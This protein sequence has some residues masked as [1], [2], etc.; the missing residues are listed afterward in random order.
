M[1]KSSLNRIAWRD[2]FTRGVICDCRMPIELCPV[3][4]DT[5]TRRIVERFGN[6]RFRSQ[7]GSYHVT[8]LCRCLKQSFLERR[9]RHVETYS[10]VWTKQRGN[11][12]HRHVSYAFS[13]WKELPIQMIIR[14]D[15]ESIRVLGHVDLFDP[16]ERELIELKSTRAVDW[17]NRK[18]LL[19]HEHH[20]KQLQCY[21]T[22]WT[23]CYDL[24][25]EKLSIAYMDDKTP[26]RSYDVELRD[27]SDW[28]QRRAILLHDAIQT[29][30]ILEAEPSGLCHY[31]TFKEI[32]ASG[33]RSLL[34]R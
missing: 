16:E 31:C 29:D 32:C 15:V 8:E 21:Y 34:A 14:C 9:H 24:P 13:G 33:Q 17:Q 20:V 4:G 28:L 7:I 12:L 18:R 1:E 26:P 23:T 5:L 30:R 27:L 3:H 2:E 6:N 10:E 22:M 11:A 25:A 19:P